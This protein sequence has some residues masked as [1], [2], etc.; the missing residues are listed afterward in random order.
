M[1]GRKQEI[2]LQL[3][4]IIDS[5][6]IAFSFWLCHAIR[7]SI[8]PLYYPDLPP[9]PDLNGFTWLM[10]IVIPFTPIFLEFEGFYKN[11][12]RKTVST[13][14]GQFARVMIWLLLLIGACV[15]FFKWKA[16]SRVLLLMLPFVAGGF[17]LA[18][19]MALKAYLLRK[20]GTNGDARERV[21]VA[22]L[23]EDIDDILTSMHVEELSGIKIVAKY[24]INAHSMEEFV[25][26]LHEQSANRVLFAAGH[27]HFGKVQDAIYACEREGVEAWLS[28]DFFQTSIARPSFDSMGGRLMLVFSST[29]AISWALFFKD[30]FDRIAAFLILLVTSPL[31]IAAAIGIKISD[32]GPVFFRQ[33]RCGRN[34]MPFMM[35]KF[36]TMCVDAEAKQQELMAKNEMDGPVFKI[37]DDPRIFKFGNLLRKLSI[38]ELPQL[39]NVLTGEMSLVGPRPLPVHEIERI[40]DT[41]QRRRLSVKPG[42]TCL[43]QI[44]GRNKITCFEDWVALDLK[45][46]DNWSM[47]LDIKILFRTIPAVLFGSGAS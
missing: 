40:E 1:I 11:P 37:E 22:G 4:Q 14:L 26:L 18:K 23:K 42:I 16:N 39:L 31:W 21:V 9:I 43:W 38:D 33:S 20:R 44:S 6:L 46:I 47:W 34:G 13:T 35:A 28:T 15:V 8:L 27:T 10:A 30:V 32:P 25:A 29:P 36:R 2:N 7:F 5:T 19:E 45:Y 3:N 12:L 17:L 41:A 24:D